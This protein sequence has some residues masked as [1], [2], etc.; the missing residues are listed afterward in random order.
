MSTFQII[1]LVVGGLVL[2][3]LLDVKSILGNKS[4][5]HKNGDFLQVVKDWEV[6][7]ASCE[8]KGLHEASQ[9]L[10]E[11]FPLLINLRPS[12][13]TDIKKILEEEN[14]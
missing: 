6:F 11:I 4:S 8:S 9:K 14:V 5:S 3:S 1:L 13:E 7:K 2:F 12:E 10:D